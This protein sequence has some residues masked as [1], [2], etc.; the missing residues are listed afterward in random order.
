MS[1]CPQNQ[2]L[3]DLVPVLGALCSMQPISSL[4]PLPFLTVHLLRSKGH[5]HKAIRNFSAF[6]VPPD[7]ST[8]ICFSNTL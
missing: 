3:A 7:P 5:L 2:D 4:L 8:T 1:L 6:L